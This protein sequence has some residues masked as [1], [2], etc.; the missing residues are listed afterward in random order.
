M[1]IWSCKIGEIDPDK[2][3]HP[4][5]P[6]MRAAVERAYRELTGEEATFVFSGWG[7]ELTEPERAVLEDRIPSDV[8]EQG[9][10]AGF[11]AGKSGLEE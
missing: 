3:P 11:E 6:P 8:Y 9:W 1:K 5:D 2:L 7:A 10:R 4:G